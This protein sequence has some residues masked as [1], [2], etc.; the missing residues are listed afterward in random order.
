MIALYV[1][2]GYSVIG[3]WTSRV[4]YGRLR[5][6]KIAR[7]GLETYAADEENAAKVLLSAMWLGIIW[8]TTLILQFISAKPPVTPQELAAK[9][10]AQAAYIQELE[11]RLGINLE[12]GEKF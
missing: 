5:A 2:V 11:I 7:M 1:V 9:E 8:P 10:A 4:N 6:K 12:K 3:I